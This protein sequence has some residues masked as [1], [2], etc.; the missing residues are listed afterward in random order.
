MLHF[1]SY[2]EQ[3]RGRGRSLQRATRAWFQERPLERVAYQVLKYQG[4]DGWTM[5]DLLR[6]AHPNP[7]KVAGNTPTHAPR[8]RLYKWITKGWE[9]QEAS[10]LDDEGLALISAYERVKSSQ[11]AREVA[12]L[13][14]TYH[15]PR[16]AV[17]T[18]FLRSQSVWEALLADMPLEALVRNLATMTRNGVLEEMGS[19]TRSVVIRLHDQE[20][21]KRARLHPVKILAALATYEQGHG[22]RGSHTWKPLREIVDA[23]NDAFYLSFESIAPMTKRVLLAIDVSYSMHGTQVNGIP[24]MNCHTAAGAMAMVLAR[25]CWTET[26]SGLKVPNFHLMG[27]DTS[28]HALTISPSSRLDDIVRTLIGTG[29]GGTNCAIP[30]QWALEREKKFDAFVLLS[31]S[32]S[33]VGTSH[34]SQSLEQY[35]AKVNPAARIINVQMAATRTSV[36]DP[37]DSLSLE[38]IGFD[39]AVPEIIHDFVEGNI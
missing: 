23:L 34:A 20:A 18:Q 6:L 14:E 2:V 27:F 30:M 17:P 31:D 37:K 11:E 8:N 28:P 29:G 19:F 9:K 22:V 26:I 35:R 5:R 16:E 39:T 32:E 4:R 21:I 25:S 15:L 36:L 3:W 24:G 38:C 1:Q 7:M 12:R 13:I 33:W 10:Y